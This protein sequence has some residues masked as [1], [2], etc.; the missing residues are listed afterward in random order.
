VV[1]VP[2]P[3]PEGRPLAG[4]D[5]M[6]CRFPDIAESSPAANCVAVSPQQSARYS[7]RACHV[8]FGLGM[9]V[10]PPRKSGQRS[11]VGCQFL[12]VVFST[13]NRQLRTDNYLLSTT[14]HFLSRQLSVVG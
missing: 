3:V 10:S 11:V 2:A 8:F 12:A 9:I 6:F 13:D 14:L 1:F 5:A 7:P 4:F